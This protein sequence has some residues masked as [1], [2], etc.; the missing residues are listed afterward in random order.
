LAVSFWQGMNTFR[1]I[2]GDFIA[3]YAAGEMVADGLSPYDAAMHERYTLAHDASGVPAWDAPPV[4]ASF[5]V[6]SVLPLRAAGALL[7]IGSYLGVGV[8]AWYVTRRARAS[9]DP[10]DRW[11]PLAIWAMGGLVLLQTAPV[12]L[13][14]SLG[15]I[16]L[17]C[18]GIVLLVA[19]WVPAVALLKP[20]TTGLTA[21]A[22]FGRG[23]GL[24]WPPSA[25]S[26]RWGHLLVGLGLSV[27]FLATPGWR[28]RASM[29]HTT[30]RFPPPDWRRCSSR[31]GCSGASQPVLPR[32]WCCSTW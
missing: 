26:L 30:S 3:R 28:S 11:G 24:R 8:L 12:R 6:L 7:T 21:A 18:L 2:T 9:A 19:A 13:T 17:V 10:A 20:Q 5:R 1:G 22:I 32:S 27:A 23:I 15:Q 16:D 14:L 25:R 31:S 4:M 29:R